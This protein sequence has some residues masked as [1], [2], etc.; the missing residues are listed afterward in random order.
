MIDEFLLFLIDREAADD[1]PG[2]S[3]GHIDAV[4]GKAAAEGQADRL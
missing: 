2:G 4:P 1:E 3:A